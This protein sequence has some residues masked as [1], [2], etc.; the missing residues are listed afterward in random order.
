[1]G[2]KK[3]RLFWE[4]NNEKGKVYRAIFDEAYSYLRKLLSSEKINESIIKNHLNEWKENTAH[5]MQDVMLRMLQ[6]I[7]NKQGMPKSIGNVKDLEPSLEDFD[8]QRIIKRYN[9]SWEKLFEEIKQ[10]HKPK[11]RMS[12]EKPNNYWVVFCKGTISAANFLSQFPTIKEFQEF[13]KPFLVNDF[14]KASL[15]LLLAKE[16]KGLGFALACD[17]LKEIGYKDYAKPDVHIIEIFSG[18]GLSKS[19]D[20]YEVFKEVVRFS[21]LINKS[22]YVVDKIFWLVGSGNFY[23][24]HI[25]IKTNRD[26]FIRYIKQKYGEILSQ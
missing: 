3:V 18:I 16:I 25:K 20:P 4:R 2:R 12:M 26:E 15:P 7:S 11:S 24:D 23:R 17:F 1:M 22:P 9:G 6:S 10:N 21:K 8:P 13:V 14:T 19:K 5:S